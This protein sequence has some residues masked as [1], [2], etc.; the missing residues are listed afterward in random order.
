MERRRFLR[1]MV[2]LSSGVVAGCL[3][4]STANSEP[5]LYENKSDLLPPVEYFSGWQET[6]FRNGS[7]NLELIDRS[8]SGEPSVTISVDLVDTID[9]ARDTIRIAEDFFT[10]AEPVDIADAG[11]E[12]TYRNWHMVLFREV[13]AIGTV[14]ANVWRPAGDGFTPDPELAHTFAED[15]YAYWQDK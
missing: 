15:L 6:D 13:N 14:G 1:F 4:D 8:A 5:E 9:T 11:V 7:G 12:Y 3:G 10:G 2:P